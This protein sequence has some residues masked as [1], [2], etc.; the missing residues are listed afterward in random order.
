MGLD[1]FLRERIERKQKSAQEQNGIDI[2]GITE[3]QKALPEIRKVINAKKNPKESEPV[4]ISQRASTIRYLRRF[5]DENEVRELNSLSTSLISQSLNAFG[6]GV[7]AV[8][9]SASGFKTFLKIGTIGQLVWG[10]T[11]FFSVYHLSI[12]YFH[13]TLNDFYDKAIDKYFDHLEYY[14]EKGHL[15]EAERLQDL[16]NHSKA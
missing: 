10:S 2:L 1:D 3:A 5:M 14:S 13:S 4:D 7:W 16:K 11:V 6:F 12:Y 8:L 15:E 9:L